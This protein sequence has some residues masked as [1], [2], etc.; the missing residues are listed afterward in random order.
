MTGESWPRLAD[1]AEHLAALRVA[2][3]RAVDPAEAVRRNLS[4]E[5]VGEAGF[6][7]HLIS[8]QAL[9]NAAFHVALPLPKPEPN[10]PGPQRVNLPR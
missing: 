4:V 10:D 2:A 7:L 1:W 6:T 9:K 5:E 3:L 8:V